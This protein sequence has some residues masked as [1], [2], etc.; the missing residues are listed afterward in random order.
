MKKK[1]RKR[2]VRNLTKTADD[3][4]VVLYLFSDQVC[5]YV[6]PAMASRIDHAQIT[7]DV[8]ARDLR[9]MK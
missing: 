3:L 6:S 1:Q 9:G 2:E 8:V 7:I 4:S 5:K